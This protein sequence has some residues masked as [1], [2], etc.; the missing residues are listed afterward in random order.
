MNQQSNREAS[1]SE[2]GR[3]E[4][5]LSNLKVPFF[6]EV[7]HSNAY[8]GD[9]SNLLADN[10]SIRGKSTEALVWLR[11]GIIDRAHDLVQDAGSGIDAYIHGMIHRLEGDYWNAKYWFRSAGKNIVATV[12]DQV[13][14]SA[15][16]EKPHQSEHASAAATGSFDPS[17]LVDQIEHHHRNRSLRSQ[18]EIE[19]QT[20]DRTEISWLLGQE[21][22]AV[23]Q[24]CKD[25]L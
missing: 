6:T 2:I 18:R 5:W 12:V 8:R 15:N 4:E 25:L 23:W 14:S 24:I 20:R 9:V 3:V 1:Q 21:W 19:S 10:P 7:D 17:R 22:R 13:R 11:V 16:F